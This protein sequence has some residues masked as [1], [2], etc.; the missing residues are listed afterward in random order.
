M[1]LRNCRYWHAV[2]LLEISGLNGMTRWKT[3]LV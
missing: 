1:A 2:L 3:I